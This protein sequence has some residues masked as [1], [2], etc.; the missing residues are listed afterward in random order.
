MMTSISVRHKQ[1]LMELGLQPTCAQDARNK[2]NLISNFPHETPTRHAFNRLL[3]R[4][5]FKEF[6]AKGTPFSIECCQWEE[7][8]I[9]VEP[10]LHRVGPT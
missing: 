3:L 9:L 8:H 1:I 5:Y 7:S 4:S 10:T 6:F 2:W